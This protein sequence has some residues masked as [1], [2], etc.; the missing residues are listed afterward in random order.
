MRGIAVCSAALAA[1]VLTAACHDRWTDY[2]DDALG[3]SAHFPASPQ[4]SH[5]Q[6]ESPF[7]QLDTTALSLEGPRESEGLILT[8]AESSSLP[9]DAPH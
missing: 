5:A 6:T 2:G 3:F 1:A 8:Y 4:R 7:G 9:S